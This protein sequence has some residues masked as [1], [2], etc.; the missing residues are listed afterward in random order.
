VAQNCGQEEMVDLRSRKMKLRTVT[1]QTGSFCFIMVTVLFCACCS[2]HGDSL[3]GRE[4]ISYY[5]RNGDG[6]VDLEIHHY[7]GVADADW[8]LQDDDYNG[9]YEKK[10]LYGV[11]IIK[12]AVNLPVP[13]NVLI[14]A[15]P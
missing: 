2:K 11:G 3:D 4:Q 1:A 9:R 6:K 14:E 12:S 13:T 10:I 15:N 7:L 8:S 5:D